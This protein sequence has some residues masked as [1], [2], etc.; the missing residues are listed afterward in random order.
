MAEL[1]RDVVE[2]TRGR[3]K[4]E[5]QSLGVSYE[6]RVESATVPPVKGIASEL[7][8]VFMNLLINGLDA[9]SGGGQFVFRVSGDAEMVTITAEDTGCGMSEETRRK[10]LEPFFTTKGARG[11]GLGLAVSW[12]IVKRHGGTIEIE[13]TVGMGSIFTIR[14]PISSGD[15]APDVA[16]TTVRQIRS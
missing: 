6:V 14:L 16:E 7:R 2:L 11:T 8:E 9:M 12:G 5:A 13:S 1:L 15:S 3:W 10:V 4:D